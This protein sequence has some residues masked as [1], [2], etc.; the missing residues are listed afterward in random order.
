M[1]PRITVAIPVY[2]MEE[3][4]EKAVRSVME[5]TYRNFELVVVDDGSTDSTPAILD[6]LAAEDGRVRVIHQ[7][8]Q[9]RAGARSTGVK[10][11]RGEYLAWLDADDWMEKEALEKLIGAIDATGAEVA[12][13]NY[14]N[15]ELSGKRMRRYAETE[16]TVITGREALMNVLS[17]K[18]TQS[19]C[20]NLAQTAIYR[21][22]DFPTGRD[23]EDVFTSYRL[24]E[25]TKKVAIVYDSELFGRLVR[26]DSVSHI[27]KIAQRVASCTAYLDRQADLTARIPE[28]EC[29]FVRA[30]FAS[31]LLE[32]RVAVFRDTRK[33]YSDNRAAI[34]RICAYFRA[35]KKM[36]LPENARWQAKLEYFF[37]T[38]GTRAGFYCSRLASLPRKN[39]TWLRD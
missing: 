35:R 21:T 31:L 15:V 22:F 6:S 28:T 20:F 23:F 12:L 39:G 5:Q 38:S 27:Q 32:L 16:N 17:R 8:N 2:N 14:A 34:K 26:P 9:G 25:H 30:N 24:Y 7:K 10:N 11:A 36:A 18:F 29:V 3:T 4:V 37:I 19:L 1:Q 13:C 33:A